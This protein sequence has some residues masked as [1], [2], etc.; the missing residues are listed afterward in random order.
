MG[1]QRISRLKIYSFYNLN[2]KYTYNSL[3]YGNV[4]VRSK[5]DKLDIRINKDIGGRYRTEPMQDSP[6][7]S[8]S[9]VSGPFFAGHSMLS[10]KRPFMSPLYWSYPYKN[11]G[12]CYCKSGLY[13]TCTVHTY[14]RSRQRE[15]FVNKIVPC[16]NNNCVVYT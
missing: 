2:T 13:I 15:I 3:L 16:K 11:P 1:G 9:S 10:Y 14:I 6:T 12:V 5:A 8:I 4:L 7:R